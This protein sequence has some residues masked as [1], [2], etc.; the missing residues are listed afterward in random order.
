MFH[1]INHKIEIMVKNHYIS[2]E[3]LKEK[4]VKNKTAH[5]HT[6]QRTQNSTHART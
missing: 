2:L 3:W 1:I 4:N 5:M 6:K